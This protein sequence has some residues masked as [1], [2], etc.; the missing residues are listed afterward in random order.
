MQVVTYDSL[1]NRWHVTWFHKPGTERP[2]ATPSSFT[3][4]SD[5]SL[6]LA[7]SGHQH[8]E[9][10]LVRGQRA[11]F[12]LLRMRDSFHFPHL[13]QS[14]MIRLP[15]QYLPGLVNHGMKQK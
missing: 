4:N 8:S 10:E 7:V 3:A 1:A 5:G 11:Q 9:S 13:T 14:N 2:Q 15:K 12:R 6:D